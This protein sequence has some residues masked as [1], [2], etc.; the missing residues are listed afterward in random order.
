MGMKLALGQQWWIWGLS[1]IE[2]NYAPWMQLELRGVQRKL[3][4][5]LEGLS[6]REGEGA[7]VLSKANP[8]SSSW[9]WAPRGWGQVREDFWGAL[10]SIKC[11]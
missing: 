4:G 2:L 6:N 5:E 3:R 7:T 1:W 11:K 10:A 8:R 9:P